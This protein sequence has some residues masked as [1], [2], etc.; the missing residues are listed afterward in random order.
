ME[1]NEEQKK[2]KAK[3]R[4]KVPKQVGAAID[5]LYAVRAD[6]K[7]LQARMEAE[8]E[9]EGLIEEKILAG[10]GKQDLEGAKGKKAQCSI[11]RSDVP[12]PEDWDAIERHIKRTGEFD[13]LH[14]RLTVDAIRE[15]WA[16]GKTVPGVGLFTKIGLSLTKV[17]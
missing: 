16:A 2:P 1:N 10:F 11:K 7:A 12:T 8:K 15:R 13:L 14:R 17:K 3:L 9:Q 5:L 6:R 4:Y